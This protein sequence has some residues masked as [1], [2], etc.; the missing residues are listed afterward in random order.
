MNQ[1][2]K[3]LEEGDIIELKKRNNGTIKGIEPIGKAKYGW[4]ATG[5]GDARCAT[6]SN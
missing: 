6:L 1:E 3:L 2:P 5:G 4:V